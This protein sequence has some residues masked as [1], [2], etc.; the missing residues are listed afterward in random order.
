MCSSIVDIIVILIQLVVTVAIIML[1]RKFRNR[2]D[3]LL[4]KKIVNIAMLMQPVEISVLP[5]L[6]NIRRV[7]GEGD[8][9]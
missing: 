7:A 4:I 8:V 5:L 6:F 9:C 3:V 2:T 1:I